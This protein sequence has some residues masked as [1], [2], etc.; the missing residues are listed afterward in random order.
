MVVQRKIEVTQ[1]DPAW[2]KRYEKEAAILRHIFKSASP[3]VHHIGSTSVPDMKAKPTIDILTV[4]SAETD[5]PFF[6]QPM[7]K[8]GYDCRGECLDAVIPGTPG[9]F[10]YVRKRGVEHLTHVHVCAAGHYQINEYLT[11]R[12]YLRTH[13]EKATLY[14][15]KKTELAAR[16]THDNISYMNGKGAFVN[17]LIKEALDWRATLA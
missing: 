14:A 7:S 6:D 15:R 17:A 2:V 5:I 13:P 1:Y 4:V 3:H 12:D 10:Y 16:F 8:E 11:F 9:R